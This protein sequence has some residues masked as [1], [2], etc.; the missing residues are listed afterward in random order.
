MLRLVFALLVAALAGCFAPSHPVSSELRHSPPI[1]VGVDHTQTATGLASSYDDY[2]RTAVQ[3]L[4]RGSGARWVWV[5]ARGAADVRLRHEPN[6]FGGECGTLGFHRFFD[7]TVYLAPS[8]MSGGDVLV[9]VAAH[10]LM[11][12]A[13]GMHICRTPGE[14]PDAAHPDEQCSPVGY[15]RA[16]LNPYV[17]YREDAPGCEP[18]SEACPGVWVVLELTVLDGAVLARARRAG[19]SSGR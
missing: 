19:A 11:H 18:F 10:E 2:W 17:F 16:V 14:L 8:C 12:W 9:H 13:G 15:G 5:G 1:R 4:N 7:D 6:V 3:V